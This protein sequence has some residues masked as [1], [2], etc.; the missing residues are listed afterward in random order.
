MP[1][2][3]VIFKCTLFSDEKSDHHESLLWS[4]ISLRLGFANCGCY[5]DIISLFTRNQLN[6]YI[7]FVLANDI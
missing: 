1:T 6:A 7:G 2:K 4:N 3:T 5:C